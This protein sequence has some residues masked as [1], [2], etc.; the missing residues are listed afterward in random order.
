MM[1]VEDKAHGA[2]LCVQ[3]FVRSPHFNQRNFFFY[4]GIAMLTESAPI[5][6]S[7]TTSVLYEPE[8]HVEIAS[9]SQMLVDVY[10]CA[11]WAVDRR[12]AVEVS[13]EQWYAVGGITPFSEDSASHSEVGISNMVARGRVEYVPVTAPALSTPGPSS[14]RASLEMSEKSKVSRNPDKFSRCIQ[15]A[16]PPESPPQEFF[17]RSFHFWCSIGLSAFPRKIQAN[18]TKPPTCSCFSTRLL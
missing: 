17:G 4:F 6:D 18:W 7:N 5:S 13:P 8:S 11:N 2:P 15:V 14:L 10:A 9:R 3:D 16:S 1:I 12:R